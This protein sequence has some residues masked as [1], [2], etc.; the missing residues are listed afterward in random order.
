MLYLVNNLKYVLSFNYYFVSF[1]FSSVN[2]APFAALNFAPSAC[3]QLLASPQVS[4]ATFF[5]WLTLSRSSALKMP[6]AHF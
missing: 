6:P 1:V 3:A 4:N 5:S 2:T